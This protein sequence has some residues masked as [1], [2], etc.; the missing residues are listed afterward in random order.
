MVYIVQAV[1]NRGDSK[2][3]SHAYRAP[4]L[5]LCVGVIAG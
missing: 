3:A 1:Y 5:S 4:T 2:T